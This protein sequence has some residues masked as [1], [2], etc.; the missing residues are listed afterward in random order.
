[1]QALIDSNPG[2]GIDM[3]VSE[4]DVGVFPNCDR[5]IRNWAKTKWDRS[6]RKVLVL[7][8]DVEVTKDIRPFFPNENDLEGAFHL[9]DAPAILTEAVR[10]LPV[11]L[12]STACVLAPLAVLMFK[13]KVLE[14]LIA[15]KYDALFDITMDSE[16]RLASVVTHEGFSIAENPLLT[17][18]KCLLM[19]LPKTPSNGILHPSK[20]NNTV[21]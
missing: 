10:C 18:V 1:M 17:H 21:K 2:L 4:G 20:I 5:N 15:E 12:Q 11:L 6:D 13:P 16:V 14:C 7:E 8:Y 3:W 9:S 19:R